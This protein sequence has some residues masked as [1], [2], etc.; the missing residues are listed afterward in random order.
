LDS[1]IDELRASMAIST[2]TDDSGANAFSL[3]RMLVPTS[4]MAIDERFMAIH[5]ATDAAV[6]ASKG[7]SL[8]GLAALAATLPTQVVTRLARQQAQTVDFATSNVKG[9][10]F[11]MFVAGS[12]I[13]S[14]HAIGP[15]SGVAFN[16]TLLSYNGHLDMGLNT[17]PAAVKDPALLRRFLADSIDDFVAFAH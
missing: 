15:L 12:R 6:N 4:D 14:N 2:R 11:A 10:P 9:S 17:D 13:L 1:P 5:K 3:V 16:L 7:A 8:D